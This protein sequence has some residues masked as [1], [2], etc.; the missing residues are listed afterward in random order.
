MQVLGTARPCGHSS[1]M[2]SSLH[3]PRPGAFLLAARLSFWGSSQQAIQQAAMVSEEM[4][5]AEGWI[6]ADLL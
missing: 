4:R 5:K 3:I 1:I 6:V 2:P